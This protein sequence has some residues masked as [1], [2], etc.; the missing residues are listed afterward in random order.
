MLLFGSLGAIAPFFLHEKKKKKK[1]KIFFT[2]F[3]SV[4][5]TF[6]AKAIVVSKK[7]LAP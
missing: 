2:F 1:K 4:S 5:L 6:F 7:S 3:F